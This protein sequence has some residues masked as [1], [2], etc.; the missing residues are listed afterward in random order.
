MTVREAGLILYDIYS[1][2]KFLWAEREEKTKGKGLYWKKLN[3]SAMQW[4]FEKLYEVN[5]INLY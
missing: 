5:N 2:E 4:Y 3:P 1:V